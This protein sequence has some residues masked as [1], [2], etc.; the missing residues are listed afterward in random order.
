MATEAPAADEP[1]APVAEATEATTAEATQTPAVEA[2]EAPTAE[3]TEAEQTAAT[4]APA[5]DEPA[6]PAAEPAETAVA[7]SAA[8][9]A[10]EA[11]VTAETPVADEA[12]APAGGAAAEVTDTG[13]T[14]KPEAPAAEPAETPAAETP[15]ADT[16][17]G[18]PAA[19]PGAEATEVAG[20]P[21]ADA[22]EASAAEPV[23]EATDPATTEEP[24][25]LAAEPAV[26][27]AAEPPTAEPAETAAAEPAT[28]EPAETAAGEPAA[29]PGA[30][31]TEAPAA[32]A[33]DEA[34]APAAEA[35][36]L[37]ASEATG[38]PA[39]EESAATKSATQEA[40]A[41][42][43]EQA[44]PAVEQATPAVEQAQPAV[45]A[46]TAAPTPKPV[47]RP[48]PRPGPVPTPAVLAH[49][50]PAVV[51]PVA[52]PAP[53]D[54]STE[55]G[56][57]L[58]PIE[59]A[60]AAEYGRVDA[61]GTVHVREGDG[62]RVVGQY[63]GVSEEEALSLYIRRFLDLQAQVRL[64][65]TRLSTLTVKDLD[66]T[67]AGLTSQF[68]DP[69]VVGDLDGLRAE[70]ED[71][72]EQAAERRKEI[73]AEREAAR[74]QAL[75]E[76][77]VI[78]ERAEEIAGAD[79]ARVQWRQQGEELRKLLDEWKHAQKTGV[80]LDRPSEDAL[81]K[82]FSHAR[83][84]FDRNRRQYF[85]ELDKTHGQ[86][87]ATKEQLI[88]RAEALSGS[89]DWGPTAAAYRDLMD[90]WKRAGR[91]S[92]KEDD[93][94]WARFRAAQDTFF[95]ARNARNAETDAEFGEN[96]KV[97][98]T[99]LTEAEGILPVRDLRSAKAKLR[100]IQDRWEAA[101][102]VPRGD[103]QRVE[104]RL[105]AVEEAIRDAEQREWKT[106]NPRVRARAEGAAAQLEAAIAG[107]EDDLEKAKASGDA[108]RIKD[109]T[110]ALD[111]RKSWLEQVLRAADDAR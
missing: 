28:A 15:A 66:S 21:A 33:A 2:T 43:V 100:D 49:S 73:A 90:E 52:A 59:V 16:P 37:P 89:T 102:K 4:D 41:P 71:L 62:E 79:P 61:D 47:P 64:F 106:S 36:G 31:V 92:R 44:A 25:P 10:E 8:V 95:E 23:V 99:I 65:G 103:L 38:A 45:S 54:A 70:L 18:E 56:P 78:V 93:A 7:E 98:L 68:E 86:V 105:R 108:R 19:V 88:E 101:G 13:T 3:A 22:A 14:E 30:Q 85:A 51:P 82:R 48:G 94:L 81:W 42:A 9:P 63:P 91:A 17:A 27:A 110:E 50:T 97:K 5:A 39:A 40:P 111:A 83:S 80:R 26:A 74:A 46:E 34:E 58:D 35:A 11:A 60:A 67:L 96:L 32:P 29:A 57:P 1:E 107:L 12:E 109:A 53:V 76:R 104:A 55:A 69:A 24:R 20:A 6:A 77:T 72:R 87:K 84:Q 75:A